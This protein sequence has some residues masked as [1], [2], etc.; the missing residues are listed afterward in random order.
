[1][2]SVKALRF[3]SVIFFLKT[4]AYC[5]QACMSSVALESSALFLRCIRLFLIASRSLFQKHLY[6]FTLPLGMQAV[7]HL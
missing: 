1:M 5:L 7:A 2:K 3:D 6:P 4:A